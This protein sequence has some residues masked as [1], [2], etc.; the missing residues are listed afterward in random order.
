MFI[1]PFLQKIHIRFAADEVLDAADSYERGFLF[2]KSF[3]FSP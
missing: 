1:I 3:L 2:K